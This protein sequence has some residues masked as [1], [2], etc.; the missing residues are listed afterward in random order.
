MSDPW[1]RGYCVWAGSGHWSR[2]GT[3]NNM[4]SGVPLCLALVGSL[5]LAVVGAGGQMGPWALGGPC[6]FVVVG[7]LFGLSAG[8]GGH[9]GILAGLAF[10]LSETD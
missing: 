5:P 9:W 1:I 4:H 6:V 3:L 7:S 2:V 10:R 8:S